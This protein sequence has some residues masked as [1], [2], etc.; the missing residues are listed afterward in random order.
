[1]SIAMSGVGSGLPINEWI[2]ALV[3]V[4]Q[5]KIDTL[6]AEQKALNEKSTS[7]N[8]LKSTYSA[9]NTATLKFTDSLYGPSSDIFTKVSATTSDEEGKFLTATATQL[10]TPAVLK[11]SVKQLATST[12]RKTYGPDSADGKQLDFSDSSKKL[13]ELGFDKE[14][15]FKI[16]GVTFN[17]SGD[18]TIDGLIYD[19]NNSADAGVQAH[20]EDGQIVLESTE[21]GS[22][23]ITVEDGENSDFASWIGW[24]DDANLTLGQNAIFTVNGKEKEAS[25]NNLSSTELGITGL[26]VELKEVTGDEIIKI[27]I[28]RESDVDT[29]YS[30][31][32]SF[33]NDFNKAI[34]D[35]DSL[36]GTEGQL[37]GETQLVSIRNRLRNMVTSTVNPDGV[38]KSLSDIGITSGAPGMDV[39]AD[40]TSLVIDKDK[41]YEAFKSNPA[42]VKELLIGSSE[43]TESSGSTGSSESQTGLMQTIQETLQAALST[44]NGYFTARNESLSSEINNLSNKITRKEEDLETYRERITQQFNYMDQQIAQLNNQFSQMQS[45]LA[46]IGVNTG[47]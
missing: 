27:N 5:P 39:D 36:T 45:Q 19:I 24:N 11:I 41:F 25:T 10:A 28:K 40:T 34:N 3:E 2:E 46:S 7:L 15:S 22:K 13:S 4:Q 47:S 29:V 9:V 37:H 31:L 1:M 21:L 23:N 44:E 12:S 30:A 43:S 32:E 17:V 16:N 33:V 26:S 42:A 18:T 35:T 14:G 6:L 38:Y 20:I 8:T